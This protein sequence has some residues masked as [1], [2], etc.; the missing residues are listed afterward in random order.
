ME[1][2]II[3]NTYGGKFMQ[4]GYVRVSS[5]TQNESRQVAELLQRGIPHKNIFIDKQSGKDFE[6]PQYKRLLKKLKTDDVLFVKSIDRFGRNY[7]EILE[8]WKYLTKDK[9]ID[10]VILD[11]PLLDT[12]QDK[13]LLG[14]MLSDIVLQVLSYVAQTQRESIKRSQAEGIRLAKKRGTKFGRPRA[15]QENEFLELYKKVE[16]GEWDKKM[17][18]QKTGISTGTY[19]AC[20]NRYLHKTKKIQRKA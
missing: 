8:Q 6:R 9:K 17:F 7:Q 2:L 14:E 18:C 1:T 15:L 19:Y 16:S 5:R 10:I 11:M 4:Y 3:H 12:R 20:I 13:D